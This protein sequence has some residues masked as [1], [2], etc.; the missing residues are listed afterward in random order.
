MV[1]MVMMRVKMV[2]MAMAIVKSCSPEILKFRTLE[3]LK[4]VLKS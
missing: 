3:V 1:M 4:S 2:M